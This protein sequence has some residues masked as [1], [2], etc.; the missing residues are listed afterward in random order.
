MSES[1]DCETF[2]LK[3]LEESTK[4]GSHVFLIRAS[5]LYDYLSSLITTEHL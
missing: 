5:Q 3:W 4:I 2:D 1:A